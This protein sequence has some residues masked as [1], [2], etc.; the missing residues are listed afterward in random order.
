MVENNNE[1]ENVEKYILKQFSGDLKKYNWKLYVF[2]QRCKK[3]G[4]WNE[5]K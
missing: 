4:K 2:R 1:W 3:K 5:K